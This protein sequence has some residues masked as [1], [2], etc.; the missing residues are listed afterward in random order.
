VV[1]V[2]HFQII[3]GDACSLLALPSGDG[4]N[5]GNPSPLLKIYEYLVIYFDN[6]SYFDVNKIP[7]SC[8]IIIDGIPNFVV[9]FVNQYT[10]VSIRYPSFSI[11]I[12]VLNGFNL[13]NNGFEIV[14]E[15]K[16]YA[17]SCN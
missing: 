4:F 2:I 12:S 7:F 15:F 16:I 5:W 11:K 9:T 17:P 10:G 6:S 13:N 8:N 3:F 14:G 1:I